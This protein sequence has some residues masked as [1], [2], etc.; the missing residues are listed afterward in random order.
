M[1]QVIDAFQSS[2][3]VSSVSEGRGGPLHAPDQDSATV[4]QALVY[5][6]AQQQLRLHPRKRTNTYLSSMSRRSWIHFILHQPSPRFLSM[7]QETGLMIGQ[8][9][10]RTL[11]VQGQDG[12]VGLSNNWTVPADTRTLERG[13]LGCGS[14]WR[15]NRESHDIIQTWV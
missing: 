9:L 4:A 11:L 8:T 1:E 14:S 12:A 6:P 3:P 2:A 5:H 7:K 10:P 13:C 15:D